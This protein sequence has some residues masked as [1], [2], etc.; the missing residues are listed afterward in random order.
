MQFQ[1]EIN[2]PEDPFFSPLIRDHLSLLSSRRFDEVADLEDMDPED[3]KEYHSML[4]EFN[5][6]PGN[7]FSDGVE[8]GITPDVTIRRD[9]DQWVVLTN[10]SGLPRVRLNA[11]LRALIKDGSLK[12]KDRRFAD[13]NC[14]KLSSLSN[15]CTD[16]STP[17]YELLAPS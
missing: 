17:C 7:L 2:Y 3:V 11:T 14:G 8:H 12:G 5:P 13:D 15:H 9:G 1:A 6:K 16:V 10:D 4:Q